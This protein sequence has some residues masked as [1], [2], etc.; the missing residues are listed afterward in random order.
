[1]SD[2]VQHKTNLLTSNYLDGLKMFI[3][4]SFFIST[5]SNYLEYSHDITIR[6][7]HTREKCIYLFGYIFKTL[8]VIG[9]CGRCHLLIL[10]LFYGEFYVE[11]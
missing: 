6:Y 3:K 2:I 11:H 5:H 8:I 10:L 4:L 7:I 9:N 1:M